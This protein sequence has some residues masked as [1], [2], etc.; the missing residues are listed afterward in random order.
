MIT[1]T[2]RMAPRS[3][4]G[5]SCDRLPTDYPDI[6]ERVGM[7]LGCVAFAPE[8]TADDESRQVLASCMRIGNAFVEGR[9]RSLEGIRGDAQIVRIE[10]LSVMRKE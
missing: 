3:V 1:V 5:T 2:Q 6:I 7:Q 9:K 10:G 4:L 8:R